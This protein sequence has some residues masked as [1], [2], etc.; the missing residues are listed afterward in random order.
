[1]TR[2]VVTAVGVAGWVPLAT[3]RG[4]RSH[5]ADAPCPRYR[6]FD[7]AEARF[8]EAACERLI[9]A[10]DTGS[11]ATTAGV[12][13]YLDRQLAG[14]WGAGEQPYRD[15]CWQPGTQIPSGEPA[16]TPAALFRVS[17]R[18]IDRRLGARGGL[19]FHRLPV[20]AQ[21]AF[22]SGLQ[23]GTVDFPGVPIGAF[24]AALLGMSVEGFFSH[25]QHGPRRDRIAWRLGGFPGAH[26]LK[27]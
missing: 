8:I 21:D 18:A 1:M 10:D 19:P 9:P 4:R 11:G 7:A 20:A 15:G 6:F 13:A 3:V 27:T 25:P 24:F 16:L 2:S 12:A 26:A 5:A 17:L 14:P 22:L 23:D